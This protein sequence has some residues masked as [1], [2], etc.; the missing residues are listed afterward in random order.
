MEK[1]FTQFQTGDTDLVKPRRY[2]P[3]DPLTGND[4][5]IPLMN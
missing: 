3:H 1:L 2:G 4:Y 5:V